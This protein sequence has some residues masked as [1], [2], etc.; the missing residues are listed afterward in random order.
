VKEEF[1]CPLRAILVITASKG[2]INKGLVYN[3]R[4]FFAWSFI[5]S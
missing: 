1:A 2:F 5:R 3:S 4:N